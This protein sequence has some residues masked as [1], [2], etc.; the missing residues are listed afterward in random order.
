MNKIVIGLRHGERADRHFTNRPN[1]VR[2]DPCLTE[3]GLIQAQ[4]SAER[5][6]SLVPNGATVHV[7]CSPFLR[8]IETA[9][10]VSKAFGVPVHVEK[11]FGEVLFG[12]DFPSNPVNT[13]NFSIRGKRFKRK[14]VAC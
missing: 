1:S 10:F 8:T 3:K 7:V 12:F 14:L 11:G 4:Q 2:Y 5:I 13:L 6:K 9:S